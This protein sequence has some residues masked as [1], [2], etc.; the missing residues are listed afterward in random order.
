MK[1]SHLLSMKNKSTCLMCVPIEALLT[2]NSLVCRYAVQV[3]HHVFLDFL[4]EIHVPLNA[5]TQNHHGERV[6]RTEVLGFS[7]C[8][9]KIWQER[10][11]VDRLKFIIKRWHVLSRKATQRS[12]GRNIIWSSAE[13]CSL[14]TER[15]SLLICEIEKNIFNLFSYF[16]YNSKILI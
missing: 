16:L 13:C 1:M 5:P 3:Q 14:I 8:S 15:H 2:K 12:K 10:G 9:S 11:K 4:M 7:A 6:S